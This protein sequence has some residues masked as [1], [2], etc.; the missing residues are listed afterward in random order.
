MRITNKDVA[1]AATIFS[2]TVLLTLTNYFAYRANP[3]Y[4]IRHVDVR[5]GLTELTRE[6]IMDLLTTKKGDK[7]KVGDE[8]DKIMDFDCGKSRSQIL[9]DLPQLRDISIEKIFP[10]TIRISPV[11]RIPVARINNSRFVVDPDGVVMTLPRTRNDLLHSLPVINDADIADKLP[12]DELKTEK[13]ITAV[14]ALD[15]F[16]KFG[17]PGFKIVMADTANGIYL[18]LYTDTGKEI[19]IPWEDMKGTGDIVMALK[20]A[21]RPVANNRTKR[22]FTVLINEKRVIAG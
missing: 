20:L 11:D 17:N 8:G 13:S 3:D 7:I 1:T 2:A 12:G 14:S 4:R 16:S 15:C 9:R 6:Q 5:T 18:T 21:A 10:N 19:C 22:R